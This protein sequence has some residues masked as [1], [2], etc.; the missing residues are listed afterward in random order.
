MGVPLPVASPYPSVPKAAGEIVSQPAT[1]AVQDDTPPV[2]DFGT[3]LARASASIEAGAEIIGTPSAP[4]PIEVPTLVIP[5]ITLTAT[6]DVKT[7]EP[8]VFQRNVAGSFNSRLAF[9]IETDQPQTVKTPTPIQNDILTTQLGGNGLLGGL[10]SAVLALLGDKPKAAE[11]PAAD[12]SEIIQIPDTI[13]L[14]ASIPAP[15]AITV[16]IVT[17]APIAPQTANITQPIANAFD[18]TANVDALT[19]SLVKPQNTA[20]NKRDVS[21]LF[22]RYTAKVASEGAATFLNAIEPPKSDTTAQPVAPQL[23]AATQQIA[24]APAS[25][26]K[27]IS[28]IGVTIERLHEVLVSEARAVN[29]DGA[30]EFTIRLSPESLGKIEVK[31]DVKA[32]GY[33]TAIVQA[34]QPAT[35]DLLRQNARG[36]DQSLNSAGLKTDQNSLAFAWREQSQQSQ[37]H[38]FF[39]E[40]S[41]DSKGASDENTVATPARRW[42]PFLS[43]SSVDISA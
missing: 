3:V 29:P 36:L 19:A 28:H 40:Q 14:A 11:T 9:V 12:V 8:L 25:I 38:N 22:E 13:L 5:K 24:V 33:V 31:L 2:V 7:E 26:A 42:F 6:T 18:E 35:Y 16:A 27:P 10:S 23:A 21:S 37:P 1:I 17:P 34:E 41:E 32:D 4:L 30:R 15:P 39:G 20:D 43:Q